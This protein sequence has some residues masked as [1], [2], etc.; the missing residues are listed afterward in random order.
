MHVIAGKAVCFHEAMPC[1]AFKAYQQQ[2][3]KNA[4]ALADGMKRQRLPAGQRRHGQPSGMLVD[5][6]AAWRLT[7]KDCQI[8]LD[9]AGITVN[10]NTIPFETRSPFQ[11][12]G[13][14][15]RD[16]GLSRRAG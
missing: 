10:K 8:A 14:R 9:D 12:S 13:I 2:I 6:G 7:G 4:A 11:A 3:V 5:V 1:R 16:A 15:R